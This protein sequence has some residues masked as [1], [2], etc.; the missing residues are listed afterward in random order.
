MKTKCLI[1]LILLL[2]VSGMYAQFK[3]NADG[4]SGK[5]VDTKRMILTK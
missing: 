2:S 5:E 4:S 1:V 3:I